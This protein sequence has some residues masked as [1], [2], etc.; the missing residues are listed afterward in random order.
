MPITPEALNFH[1]AKRL[2]PISSYLGEPEYYLG[3]GVY[4]VIDG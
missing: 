2:E 4:E 1:S 3:G